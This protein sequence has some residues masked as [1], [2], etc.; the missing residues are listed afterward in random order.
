MAWIFSVNVVWRLQ[1]LQS[2][3]LNDIDEFSPIREERIVKQRKQS[4]AI[5]N[6]EANKAEISASLRTL[7]SH[8]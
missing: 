7:L 6:W 5:S 4:L 3:S 2:N 8:S 1:Y